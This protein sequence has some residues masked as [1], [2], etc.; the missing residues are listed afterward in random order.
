MVKYGIPVLIAVVVGL[1]LF[2]LY[3][4]PEREIEKE[5]EKRVEALKGELRGPIDMERADHFVDAKT[6]LSRRERRIITTTPKT[7][8]EDLSVGPKTEIKVLIE[9]ERTSITTP[10]ELMENRTIH[11]DTPIRVLKEEGVIIETTPRK[12]MADKSI[13]PDTPIKIVEKLERVA[14]TTPEELQKTAPSLDTPIKV[15]V[16]KPGE[17]VTLAQLLPEEKDVGKDTFYVHAVTREDVQGIWGII[18]RGLK[19]QF[20]KGIPVPAEEE[21][22]REQYLKLRIPNDADEPREG[23][24]SSFLGRILD[25]KTKETYVYNYR[26]GRMGKN[27]DYISPGQEVVIS[28]FSKKELVEIYKHF[29]KQL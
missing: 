29:S 17:A 23:G 6:V 11:P 15:I 25:Q 8:L 18:Q 5:V 16:E 12:L 21:I 24:Y 7:L 10:R 9:E 13:T 1:F 2:F 27:P 14:V 28:R 19:D 26:S 3:T 22:T 4:G 20:L